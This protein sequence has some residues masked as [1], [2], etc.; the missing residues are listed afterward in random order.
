M[1]GGGEPGGSSSSA[2]AASHRRPSWRSGKRWKQLKA[3]V[4]FPFQR[5]D[6]IEWSVLTH[7]LFPPFGLESSRRQPI[8]RVEHPILPK[9]VGV[10]PMETV[11]SVGGAE[12]VLSPRS[13]TMELVEGVH[14]TLRQ[15]QSALSEAAWKE[16][17]F[18]HHLAPNT[19]MFFYG[20]EGSDGEHCASFLSPLERPLCIQV[21]SY[22]FLCWKSSFVADES[23]SH[24]SS[25]SASHKR[26]PANPE[27]VSHTDKRRTR[28]SGAAQTRD[29]QDGAID[30]SNPEMIPS[31]DPE[32]ESSGKLFSSP[33]F[34]ELDSPESTAGG[35]RMIAMVTYGSLRPFQWCSE[36]KLHAKQVEQVNHMVQVITDSC[37]EYFSR[38]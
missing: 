29:L 8:G 22:G 5:L 31:A 9:H 27:S 20:G 3:E 14:F 21:L 28:S 35:V 15:L 33:S 13:V 24:F 36:K 26:S 19:C 16:L 1:R 7:L 30:A 17:S 6:A 32:T 38:S 11:Y 34:V 37:R 10:I 23:D 12:R 18:L 2:E 4:Y 25:L